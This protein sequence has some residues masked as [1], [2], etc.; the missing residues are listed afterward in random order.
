MVFKI[1]GFLY[2]LLHVVILV[3]VFTYALMCLTVAPCGAEGPVALIIPILGLIAGRFIYRGKFGRWR[4]LLI[5]M[6]VLLS[7]GLIFM[8]FFIP[9]VLK[10][11]AQ[12]AETSA[13]GLNIKLIEAVRNN[14][15]DEVRRLLNQGG[16]IKAKNEFGESVLHVVKDPETAKFLIGRG[17]DVHARNEEFNMTPIFN[18]ELDIMKVLADF[19]ADVN[20]KSVKDNTPLIWHAYSKDFEGIQYLVSKGADINAINADGNT[21]LDIAE[22]FGEQELIAFLRSLGG[23]TAEEIKAEKGTP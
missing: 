3:F 22:R 5:L 14:Q 13:S 23:N 7:S 19:G 11:T 8:S 10:K 1:V 9:A 17:A 21:A 16:S 20:A 18:Q 12:T 2:F 4:I 15:T 6:S